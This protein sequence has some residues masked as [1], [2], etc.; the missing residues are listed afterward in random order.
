MRAIASLTITSSVLTSDAISQRLALQPTRSYDAGDHVDA[1]RYPH[2]PFRKQA[3]WNLT[4]RLPRTASLAA[5]LQSLVGVLDSRRAALALLR[6]VTAPRFYC[7]LFGDYEMAAG[8]DIPA[9]VIAWCSDILE[10]SLDCYPPFSTIDEEEADADE[11]DAPDA[12]HE[13][14]EDLAFSY[15]ASAADRP[16][17]GSPHERNDAASDQLLPRPTASQQMIASDLLESSEASQH[18]H[19]VLDLLRMRQGGGVATAP[20]LTCLFATNRAAGSIV[21]IEIPILAQLAQLGAG[22]RINVYQVPSALVRL[23]QFH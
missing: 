14:R 12:A 18:F 13:R 4:S 3:L 7:G 5:H 16:P 8:F 21:R 2:G 6:S 23:R 10:I 19:R 20:E 15:L 9:D 22:F 11:A 1:K 17:L